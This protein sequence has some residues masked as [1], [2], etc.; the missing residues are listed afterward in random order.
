MIVYEKGDLLYVF[1]F[2]PSKSHEGYRVGTPWKSDHFIVYESDEARFG[3]HQRLN[4]AHN[5]WHKVYEQRQDQRD[6]HLKLYVPNRSCVI[7]C[8]YE[9][10]AAIMKANP[11][12][13][14]Q[15][16]SNSGHVP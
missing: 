4:D 13:Q 10:A 8:A 12:V 11:G 2:H 14:I 15:M 6:Y 9:N 1:N 7:L 3:G 5:H 16:P